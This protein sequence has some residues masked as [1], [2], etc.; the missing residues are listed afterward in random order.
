MKDKKIKHECVKNDILPD[1]YSM[2]IEAVTKYLKGIIKE[3]PNHFKFTV[4][5]QYHYGHTSLEV[6]ADR[7]ETDKEQEKR[8]N[9]SKQSKES[10]K[11][12]KAV[13]IAK[14]KL[15]L[16]QLKEKYEK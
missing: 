10:W 8:L 15:L 5:V 12:R 4:N 2:P 3:H 9:K 6:Q 14:D 13:K 11:K 7:Y 16:K 1:I